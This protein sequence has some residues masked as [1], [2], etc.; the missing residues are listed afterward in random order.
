MSYPGFITRITPRFNT[1]VNCFIILGCKNGLKRLRARLLNTFRLVAVSRK[2]DLYRSLRDC[3][4]RLCLCRLD[5]G[6]VVYLA[7]VVTLIRCLRTL[8]NPST[9]LLNRQAML[10]RSRPAK[11]INTLLLS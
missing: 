6:W 4:L 8:V 3:N 9:V 1:V 11:C 7:A 2:H 5:M 10:P